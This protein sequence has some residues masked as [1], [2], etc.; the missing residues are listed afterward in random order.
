LRILLSFAIWCFEQVDS[1][2]LCHRYCRRRPSRRRS[3]RLC[4]LSPW[5]EVALRSRSCREIT[6]CVR[7]LCR[8]TMTDC[9]NLSD[10]VEV[11]GKKI[12]V[13]HSLEKTIL[14]HILVTASVRLGVTWFICDP[15]VPKRTL[16]C[17]KSS[18]AQAGFRDIFR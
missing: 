9:C 7:V 3:F 6:Q 16:N 17:G 15:G 14:A 11:E 18:Q 13:V 4:R 8:W 12:I 2:W 1:R 10:C 5:M